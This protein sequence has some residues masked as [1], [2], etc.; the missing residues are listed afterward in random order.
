VLVIV[1]TTT[2]PSWHLKLPTS[3]KTSPTALPVAIGTATLCLLYTDNPTVT[4][5]VITDVHLHDA[6][7]KKRKPT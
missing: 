1:T 3:P 2:K 6:I 4:A 5:A 7:D